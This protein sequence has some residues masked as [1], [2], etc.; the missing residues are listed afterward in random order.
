MSLGNWEDR[1]ERLN[2]A[3]KP[4]CERYAFD[5]RGRGDGWEQRALFL[6]AESP[7]DSRLR[8]ADGLV[9]CVIGDLGNFFRLSFI[10]KKIF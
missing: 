2:R 8:D 5:S 3:R 1:R 9:F 7:S 4:A 10:I 6:R